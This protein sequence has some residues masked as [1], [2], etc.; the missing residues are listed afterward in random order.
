MLTIKNELAQ[1]DPKIK[2][3][4]F[5]SHCAQRLTKEG[6]CAVESTKP[7]GST[8]IYFLMTQ[9]LIS[10]RELKETKKAH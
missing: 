3:L 5:I 8:L 6:I 9:M 7:G 1:P 10:N 4:F 2:L